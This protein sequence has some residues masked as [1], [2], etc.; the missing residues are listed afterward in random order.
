MSQEL[1]FQE[2]LC[3]KKN[4]TPGQPPETQHVTVKSVPGKAETNITCKEKQDKQHWRVMYKPNTVEEK[5]RGL[6]SPED[7]IV[8]RLRTFQHGREQEDFCAEGWG[9]RMYSQNKHNRINFSH[10][11]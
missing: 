4:C 5:K 8:R 10:I 1:H 11:H 2:C 3:I 9:R 6:F 7:K